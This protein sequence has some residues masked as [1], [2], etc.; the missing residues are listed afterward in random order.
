MKRLF[1]L[2]IS[3][4]LSFCVA[5][6]SE[7]SFTGGAKNRAILGADLNL[8]EVYAVTN[9]H[10]G[11]AFMQKS[12]AALL[13]EQRF[14]IA[15]IRQFGAV[16]AV[17]IKAGAF[18]LE[19]QSFG[20][21]AFRHQ[22][23]GVTYARKIFEKVALGVQFNYQNF[24]ISE[25]GNKGVLSGEIGIQA[26]VLEN[27]W[28]G[29]VLINP[30]RVQTVQNEQLSTR[31]NAGLTYHFSEKVQLSAAVHKDFEYKASAR[32]G[33]NYRLIQPLSLRL[34]IGTNPVENGFGV[35][36]HLKSIDLDFAVAYHQI[37][38]FTPAFSAVYHFSE[39]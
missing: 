16:A 19:I 13:A 26:E 18:G 14:G 29:A 23:I 30:F 9:N 12:A 25:Y 20:F 22:K 36:V 28:L 35:G 10:A 34:G 6:Q 3:F 31:L 11:I 39:L 33:L 1:L 7:E 17:P 8:Q 38:G 15:E 32:V 24:R 21:D 5:A 37:L 2:T 27:L 4:A